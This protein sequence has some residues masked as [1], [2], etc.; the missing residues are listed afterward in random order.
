MSLHWPGER[1]SLS[2]CV[3]P[4]NTR[5]EKLVVV[6]NVHTDPVMGRDSVKLFYSD[7]HVRS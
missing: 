3:S 7:L 2:R 6:A 5:M 4:T 1:D